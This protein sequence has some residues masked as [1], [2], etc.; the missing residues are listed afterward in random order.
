[1]TA[2]TQ[3]IIRK[4]IKCVQIINRLALTIRFREVTEI[5][6]VM[7]SGEAVICSAESNKSTL[8]IQQKS[9]GSKLYVKI[10]I[11]IVYIK[12]DF[13]ILEPATLTSS[14]IIFA[15]RRFG[16]SISV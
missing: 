1:M 6:R 8:I 12:T 13:G 7:K 4:S 14:F 15:L 9:D 2:N 3:R 10:R 5:Q 16:F 11:E